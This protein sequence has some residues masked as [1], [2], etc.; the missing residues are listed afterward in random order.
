MDML[1]HCRLMAGYNRR[2]NRQMLEAAAGLD[3][4]ALAADRGAFFGS[5]MGTFNHL[6]VADLLWSARFAHHSERYAHLRSL[7]EL[8]RP[9][10]LDDILYSRFA[11]L[12]SARRLVDDALIAWTA[13][14]LTEADL[15]RPLAYHNR[16]GEPATRPFGEL[17]MHF[18]NHQTHHRGQLSTLLNQQ[19]LDVGVTDFLIDI[20]RVEQ[21]AS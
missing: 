18:F 7:A 21:A 10:A 14:E 2:M 3:D 13:E 11:A 19:G 20:P 17:L 1:Y 12:A 15:G 8:P 16:L 5:L 9:Q 4:T 6:L